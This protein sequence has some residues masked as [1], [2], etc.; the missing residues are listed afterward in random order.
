MKESEGL[1]DTRRTRPTESTKRGGYG[2]METEEASTEPVWACTTS[3]V[4]ILW[5]LACRTPNSRSK[6]ISDSFA[7]SQNSFPPAGFTC[8]VSMEE[9]LPCLILSCFVVFGCCL[10]ESCCFLKGERREVDQEEG[11]CRGLGVDVFV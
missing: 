3:C 9:L 2:L 11:R 5:L 8:P 1:K 10:L 4:Y 7:C 6:S